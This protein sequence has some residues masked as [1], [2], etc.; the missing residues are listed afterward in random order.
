MNYK[1]WR[2]STY[3]SF[4][5]PTECTEFLLL[6]NRCQT[7][8]EEHEKNNE[9]GECNECI[10]EQEEETKNVLLYSYLNKIN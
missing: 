5:D 1:N 10:E 3:Q 4:D 9:L 2:K 8:L 6:C 7:E